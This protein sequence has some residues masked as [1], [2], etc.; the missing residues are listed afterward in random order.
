M[1]RGMT[2]VRLRHAD[3]HRQLGPAAQHGVMARTLSQ[4][5]QATANWAA[6]V[7]L[8]ACL[9]LAWAIIVAT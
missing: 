7:W 3:R 1:R 2:D 4:P 9:L 6:T 8:N 5:M